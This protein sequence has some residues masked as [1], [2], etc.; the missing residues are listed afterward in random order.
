MNINVC[1][2]WNK[3]T[4]RARVFF[5]TS[6]FDGDPS[7]SLRTHRYEFKTDCICTMEYRFI[8]AGK[9]WFVSMEFVEPL[10]STKRVAN[11]KHIVYMNY[12]CRHLVKNAR[13]HDTKNA[14][15]HAHDMSHRT[16]SVHI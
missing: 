12:L 14:C 15:A 8:G 5:A 13:A 10:V 1:I 3:L 16:L 9:Y 11:W 2:A 4:L 6:V 7:H